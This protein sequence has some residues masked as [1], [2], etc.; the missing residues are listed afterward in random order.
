MSE[1][2][3]FGDGTMYIIR[4]MKRAEILVLTTPSKIALE[5]LKKV[6]KMLKELNVPII[7]VIENMKRGL[8][9]LVKEELKEF[10]VPILGEIGFDDKIED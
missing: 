3:D 5:T 10:D 8:F 1:Y 9:S 6:I 7:G 2:E 4:G